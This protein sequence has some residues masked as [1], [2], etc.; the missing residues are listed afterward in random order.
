MRSSRV[1]NGPSTEL[2]SIDVVSETNL[3]HEARQRGRKL[4]VTS[5]S[6]ALEIVE[7]LVLKPRAATELVPV[8]NVDERRKVLPRRRKTPEQCNAGAFNK[9]LKAM[10]GQTALNR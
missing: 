7:P 8:M 3:S 6:K 2:R 5:A 1:C 4:W 9:A 10:M